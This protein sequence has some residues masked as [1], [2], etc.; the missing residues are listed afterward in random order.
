[1]LGSVHFYLAQNGS[2]V[3]AW[4]SVNLSSLSAARTLVFNLTSSDTD[5]IYGM[6][7]P[8]YFAM[9]DLT[10][11]S[12]VVWNGGGA[13]AATGNTW[14]AGANWGG[15]A[16]A[17]GQP[18]VFG[19][20]ASGGYTTANNSF[21]A[22][23]KFTGITF[24]AAASAYTLQGNAITLVGP[25]VNQ[26]SNNQ[27]IDL[28]M[29][30][31]A[32][33]GTLD[34]GSAGLA[35]SGDISG[36]GSGLTKLGSGTLTLSGS[37]SYSGGTTVDDGLLVVDCSQSLPAGTALYIGPGASVVLGDP[38]VGGGPMQLGSVSGSPA[39]LPSCNVNAVPEPGTL[40]LLAAAVGCGLAVWRRRP[41]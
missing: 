10:L 26:S 19:P 11:L 28:A 15:I 4:Q 36:S 14:T 21:A 7:T 5:P 34:T 6:N 31:A 16:P 12:S 30:L 32:G 29:Q 13:T 27:T 18:L 25:I 40:A 23:T 37:N 17:A 41:T 38:V 1:M 3:N 20:T 9:G 2:I 22:G 39:A 33:G 24:N 35:I 8:A